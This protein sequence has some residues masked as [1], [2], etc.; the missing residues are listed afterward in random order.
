MDH[1]P[2]LVM[3]QSCLARAHRSFF[4]HGWPTSCYQCGCVH[5]AMV[6]DPSVSMKLVHWTHDDQSMRSW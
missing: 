3:N 4:T 1:A 2:S 6:I 5:S